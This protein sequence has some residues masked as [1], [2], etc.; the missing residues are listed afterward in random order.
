[1]DQSI[2]VVRPQ[3]LRLR[4]Y[5]FEWQNVLQNTYEFYQQFGYPHLNSKYP[6][7]NF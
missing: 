4:Q 1:M 5:F 3:F 6:H 2:Y 7:F